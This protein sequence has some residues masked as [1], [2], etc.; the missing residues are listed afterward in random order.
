MGN[1]V[2]TL[3]KELFESFM[4]E[5]KLQLHYIQAEDPEQFL[6]SVEKC[7][8]LQKAINRV[9]DHLSGDQQNQIRG[10]IQEILKSRKQIDLLLPVLH[11]KLKDRYLQV[12]RQ[13]TIIKQGYNNHGLYQPS[14][15][16]D[17][18]K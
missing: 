16:F 4:A 12:E 15:F 10:I 8:E 18:R 7:E 2:F 1:E 5:T 6:I 9:P 14:V 3:K 17:K 13:Q 11:K